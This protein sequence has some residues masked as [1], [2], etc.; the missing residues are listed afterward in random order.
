MCLAILFIL[1]L[2]IYLYWTVRDAM[3]QSVSH[4]N[5]ILTHFKEVKTDDHL[6]QTGVASF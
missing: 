5:V 6:M 1:L 3:G 2:G 4:F